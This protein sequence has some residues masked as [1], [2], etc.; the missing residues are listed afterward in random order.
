VSELL[1]LGLIERCGQGRL[2]ASRSGRIVLNEVVL[3]LAS[4]L[5][6]AGA[7]VSSGVSRRS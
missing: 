1:G 4:S 2:R 5:E 7:S 3:R 6:A